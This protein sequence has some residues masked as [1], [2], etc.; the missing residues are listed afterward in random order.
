MH[1]EQANSSNLGAV[2]HSIA[3]VFT[4]TFGN[5]LVAALQGSKPMGVAHAAAVLA[6]MLYNNTA[7]K[8]KLLSVAP[9]DSGMN[10][11]FLLHCAQQQLMRI[12]AKQQGDLSN[13]SLRFR[14]VVQAP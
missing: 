8:E 14:H 9:E 4:G 3:A 5:E 2:S 12:V 7:C 11:G 10:N 13:A 1:L 6:D